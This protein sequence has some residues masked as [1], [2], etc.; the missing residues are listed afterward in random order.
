M[1]LCR[2]KAAAGEKFNVVAGETL[3]TAFSRAGAPGF[4]WSLSMGVVGD[5][6]RTSVVLAPAPYMGLIPDFTAS[7]GEAAYAKAHLNSCWELYG[8]DTRGAY[9]A[10]GSVYDMRTIQTRAPFFPFEP[11]W[12]NVEAPTCPGHPNGTFSV[13]ANATVQDVLWTIGW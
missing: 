1:G 3:W 10:T 4:G 8:V 9:P 7:W 13:S 6:A 5:A 2:A 12:R 11:T